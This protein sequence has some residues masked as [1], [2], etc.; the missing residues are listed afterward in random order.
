MEQFNATNRSSLVFTIYEN[1][2]SVVAVDECVVIPFIQ[3]T[4]LI[5]VNLLLALVGTFGNLLIIFAVLDTPQLHRRPS[6]FLLL[7]L[8]VAD[9]MVT[10]CTQP[11]LVISLAF[12]TFAHRCIPEILLAY[13]ISVNVLCSSSLAHLTV[14]S[15]DRAISIAKPHRHRSIMSKKRLKITICIC[16]VISIAIAS[17]RVPLPQTAL[18]SM[19]IFF[20][21]YATF[22]CSYGVILYN[23]IQTRNNVYAGADA[24]MQ[25]TARDRAVEKRV[26]EA[27]GIVTLIFSL[28]WLPVFIYLILVQG[29]TNDVVYSWIRT[30][31]L[32]NSS[33]NFIVYSWR[34]DHFRVAYVK[35]I[36]KILQRCR[37]SN[38]IGSR[39]NTG[40]TDSRPASGCRSSNSVH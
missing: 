7:S 1:T 37:C 27:V 19:A 23:V 38:G 33:I 25:S 6:N 16:W 14:I 31:Y 39:N 34:I 22:L 8:A 11:L 18:F 26:C 29:N 12:N 13:D 10:M 20:V 9:L 35:M 3:G 40:V 24:A 15:I 2:T 28:C 21:G 5:V 36:S 30:L 4:A 17:F 32:S